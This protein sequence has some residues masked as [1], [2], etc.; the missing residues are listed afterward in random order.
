MGEER[1]KMRYQRLR[2][3]LA[4]VASLTHGGVV[5]ANAETRTVTNGLE[6][7]ETALILRAEMPSHLLTN[8]SC[9]N[10]QAGWKIV[11]SW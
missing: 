6:V 8:E 7:H 11:P 5:Q 3:T 2:W 4:L 10:A 9:A 1:N